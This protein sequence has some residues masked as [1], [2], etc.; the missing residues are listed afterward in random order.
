MDAVSYSPSIVT[1]A[2]SCIVLEIKRDMVENHIFHTPLAFDTPIMGVPVG[3]LTYHL[4]CNY[5]YL[6]T[7]MVWLPDGAKFEDT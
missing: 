5:W 7:K 6:K 2:V 3:K 1:M 4:V